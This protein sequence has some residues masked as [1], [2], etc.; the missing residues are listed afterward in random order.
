MSLEPPV[1]RGAAPHD[2]AAIAAIYNH[3]VRETIVTFEE[4][5]VSSDE[6]ARRMQAGSA[7]NYPWFV[8]EQGEVIVGYAYASSWKSRIGYRRSVEVTVYVAPAVGR[9]G[10]GTALY[11]RLIP[12]L[13]GRG[14]HACLGG[15]ALPND[16]S[17]A[18]HEKFGFTKVA[19]LREIGT[20]FGRWIDV[21]YWQRLARPSMP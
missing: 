6:M 18:L 7:V 12:E 15:I 11:R 8:A 19:H 5:E 20:K 17:V 9:A 2:A 4:D 10:I 16:A 21:G 14:V 13:D 3:Y 1:V